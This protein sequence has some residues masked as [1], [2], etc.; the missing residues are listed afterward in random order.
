MV[1]GC[2][3]MTMDRP[4]EKGEGRVFAV[5]TE[6][7]LAYESGVI[8][9]RARIKVRPVVVFPQPLSPTNPRVSPGCK[10][11]LTP[12]TALSSGPRPQGPTRRK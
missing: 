9:L 2:Y 12:S 4:G 11:K 8:A 6:A 3:Y 7:Q 5:S 10:A 1:L